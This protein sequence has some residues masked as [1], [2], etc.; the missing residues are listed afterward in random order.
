M[1]QG[2]AVSWELHCQAQDVGHDAVFVAG[3]PV[4]QP[5][6]QRLEAA[7]SGTATPPNP[8]SP[9]S[10]A[11]DSPLPPSSAGGA[12][13]GVIIDAA[14][15]LDLGG[16]AM[17]AEAARVSSHQQ[18]YKAP[19][20]GT[21]VVRLDNRYSWVMSKSVDF[22]VDVVPAAVADAETPEEQ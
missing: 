17:V 11:A 14:P 13:R 19:G 16:A 4:Q 9:A 6:S 15:A 7:A 20:M 2:D 8:A 22:G 5:V 18:E 12:M 1:A 10:G 3:K 21:L